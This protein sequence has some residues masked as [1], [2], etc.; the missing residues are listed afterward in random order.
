LTIY[1]FNNSSSI[2]STKANPN[3]VAD[4]FGDWREEVIAFS[5][6]DSASI[7]IFT[8]T[9]PSSNRVYTLMHDPQYRMSIAWQNVAYNQ[10]PHLGYYLP[11]A[12]KK[13]ISQPDIYVPGGT[14]PV[15]SVSGSATQ[16]IL[17]GS[18]ISTITYTYTNCTSASATGLPA[19]VTAIASNGVLTISGVPTEYGTFTFTVT[20]LGGEGTAAVKTG[21]LTISNIVTQ[22]DA[23]VPTSGDGV[24]E[25]IIPV[26]K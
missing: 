8:T 6:G 21:T 17:L 11:D 16:S 10:P 19:G 14:A 22:L 4:L 18:A 15:L 1:N 9:I 25:S 24:T 7:N 5:T 23:S 12:V 3:L 2:N 13:G 20:T 26:I